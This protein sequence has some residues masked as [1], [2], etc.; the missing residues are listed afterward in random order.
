MS[1]MR[2]RPFGFCLQDSELGIYI[3]ISERLIRLERLRR[4]RSEYFGYLVLRILGLV[5]DPGKTGIHELV[6]A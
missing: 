6:R 3:R 5:I 2:R 1:E 4:R